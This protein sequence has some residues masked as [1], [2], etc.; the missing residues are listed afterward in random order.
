MK[1]V[2]DNCKHSENGFYKIKVGDIFYNIIVGD[3][4]LF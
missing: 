1:N 4:I 3:I 2:K